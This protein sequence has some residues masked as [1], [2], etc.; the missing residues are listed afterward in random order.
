V[1]V[2]RRLTDA[3]RAED[4]VARLGGDEFLVLAEGLADDEDAAGIADRILDVFAQPVILPDGVADI[5]G[6]VGLAVADRPWEHS[7]ALL[8]LADRAMYRAKQAGGQ[9]LVAAR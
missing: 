4:T 5:R 2:A 3:A 8:A 6:S 7:E 1:E 9:R